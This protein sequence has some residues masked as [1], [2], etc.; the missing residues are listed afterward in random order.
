MAFFTLSTA[1]FTSKADVLFYITTDLLDSE[2]IHVV[3]VSLNVSINADHQI[4]IKNIAGQI[5]FL[6][7][8]LNSKK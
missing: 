4:F 2:L 5:D 8:V 1:F 3:D 7:I 6:I